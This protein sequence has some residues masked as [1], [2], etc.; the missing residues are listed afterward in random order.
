MKKI[1]FKLLIIS[2]VLPI[3]SYGQATRVTLSQLAQSGATDGQFVKW[4][5]STLTWEA[6]PGSTL[7]GTQNYIPYFNTTTTLDNSG[8]FWNNTA[9][10]LAVNMTS[11]QARLTLKD[12]FGTPNTLTS[13]LANQTFDAST[14]WTLGTGWSITG[15]VAQGTTTNDYLTYTPS[16]TFTANESYL[17]TFGISEWT[18]GSIQ[19][20]VGP[21][22]KNFILAF[23]NSAYKVILIPSTS[24]TVFRFKGSNFTGKIDNVSIER[25]TS[26][27]IPYMSIED[28]VNTA[29]KLPL[30][31]PGVSGISLGDPQK[32]TLPTSSHNYSIGFSSLKNNTSGLDNISIGESALSNL[33][34]GNY[35]IAFGKESLFS[36]SSS[37]SNIGMGYRALYNSFSGT[38][39]IGIGNETLLST[40]GTRN[41]V[42]GHNSVSALTSFSGSRN[43]IIGDSSAINLAA[44]ASKNILIGAN[45]NFLDGTGNNQLN[46]GN[47]IFGLGLSGTGTTIAGTIGIGTQTPLAR[48]HIK[49]EGSLS[50]ST[51]FLIKN[52]SDTTLFLVRDDVKV[53][54]GTTNI[55]ATAGGANLTIGSSV[56]GSVSLRSGTALVGRF[57]ANSSQVELYTPVGSSEIL[58]TTNAE[59]RVYVKSDGKVGIGTDTPKSTLQVNGSFGRTTPTI[60]TSNTAYT[61]DSQT[62]PDS[63]VI[64][65]AAS[66]TIT[67]TLPTASSWTGREITFRCISDVTVNTNTNI[68]GTSYTLT[69][70][71]LSG[72]IKTATLV[73]DGTY[74]VVV[75]TN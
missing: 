52:S 5:N 51:S 2:L 30:S 46:I 11:T 61:V 31:F 55:D 24:G 72:V 12:G 29:Y 6:G 39:N 40:M 1:I 68:Y 58:L 71:L 15:G 60:V 26:Y 70:S 14:N 56:G 9:K 25:W 10:R 32:H 17:V 50:S 18:S 59:P 69:T 8:L 43:I 38:K 45:I 73:S 34:N 49:G 47:A 28:S 35:N 3:L 57:Q 66:G 27:N 20:E 67:L 4:N 16:L 41:V 48:L 64:F 42:I 13:V 22:G 23:T 53:G 21:V 37:S 54:I 7:L 65:T 19:V 75:S 63:W 62:N 33:V 44:T 36:L 74:W